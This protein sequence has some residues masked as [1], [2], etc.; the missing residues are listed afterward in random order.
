MFLSK[1]NPTTTKP[2]TFLNP[3]SKD[4]KIAELFNCF[5]ELLFFDIVVFKKACFTVMP[6][7]SKQNKMV[8]I[9]SWENHQCPC[10]AFS[11]LQ[12][13]FCRWWW[14]KREKFWEIEISA[15]ISVGKTDQPESSIQQHCGI[16]TYV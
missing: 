12:F 2:Y 15:A 6:V 9:L 3:V 7:V 14:W 13:C 5:V 16:N 4:S 10:P 8:Q 11:L 1:K